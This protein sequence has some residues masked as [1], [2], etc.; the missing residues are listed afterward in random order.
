M[1]ETKIYIVTFGIQ[2][3]Q[4]QQGHPKAKNVLNIGLTHIVQPF[5]SQTS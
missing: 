1:Q 4:Q 2:M 3:I 5:A